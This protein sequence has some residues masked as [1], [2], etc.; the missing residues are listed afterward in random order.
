MTECPC[1]VDAPRLYVKAVNLYTNPAWRR[2]GYM[3][4]KKR[5]N[6]EG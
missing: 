6:R 3:A 2:P 5:R 4:A 1:I